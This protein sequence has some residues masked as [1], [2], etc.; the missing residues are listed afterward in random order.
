VQPA[1][2]GSVPR[3][4]LR[5]NEIGDGAGGRH[6]I[7]ELPELRGLLRCRCCLA[8]PSSRRVGSV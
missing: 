4:L 3:R 8:L 2:D 5:S 7:L 1:S 6:A